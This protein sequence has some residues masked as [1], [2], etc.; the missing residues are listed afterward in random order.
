MISIILIVSFALLLLLGVPIAFA[1]AISSLFTFIYIGISPIILLQRMHDG[2]DSFTLLAIPFFI[3]MGQILEKG[4]ITKRIVTFSNILVG[5]LRG[6]LASVNIVASMFF[7]GISGSAVADVSSIGAMLI[8]LMGEEGYDRDFSVVVTATSSTIG[9]IIPPSNTMILY[10]FVAGG[11]VSIAKLYMA[12]FIPGIIIGISLLI[13]TYIISVKRKYPAH[14]FVPFR[15]SLKIAK[16]ALIGMGAIFIIVGGVVF[17]FFTATEAAVGGVAYSFF[18][19]RFIYRELSWRDFKTIFLNSIN[20]TAIVMFLIGA[21]NAFAYILAYEGIPEMI[22]NYLTNISDNKYIILLMVNVLLLLVGAVMDMSAAIII[23]TPILLPVMKSIG[24]DPIHFG[25]IIMT[26]LCIGL[27]TPPV[28]GVAYLAAAIG[29]IKP[30]K[31]FRLLF[32]YLIPM[33]IALML[34]T[35]IPQFTMWLPSL[36]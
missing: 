31:C 25:I 2:M 29:E 23:F 32:I 36:F 6:G 4:G 22:T 21:S 1:I 27:C 24:V 8:P 28:G 34:I 30:E 13:L 15:E 35:F 11:G 26:N 33:V 16:E 3:L 12:G 7:A 20:T 18:I 14:K 9:L 17:G 19:T 10:A 5:W